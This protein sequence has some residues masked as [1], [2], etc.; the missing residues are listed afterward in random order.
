M[1]CRIL[2]RNNL[3]YNKYTSMSIDMN[4]NIDD[5]IATLIVDNVTFLKYISPNVITSISLI[6]NFIILY[7]LHNPHGNILL[8]SVLTVRWLTDL[9]DGAVARKYNK[10]SVLGG[11][12]DTLGDIIFMLIFA[13]YVISVTNIP[14]YIFY[15]FTALVIGYIINENTIHD[16]NGLKH[17]NGGITQ[18]IIA[19]FVNNSYFVYMG[20]FLFSNIW[21]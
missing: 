2:F 20:L 21:G 5:K 17:Y 6:L 10:V 15:V 14:M 19:F 9:L 12:L 4:I 7:I 16:H 11:I 13:Y 1:L 18:K 8:G 3:Y